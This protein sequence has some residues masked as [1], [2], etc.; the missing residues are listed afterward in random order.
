MET[1][2]M[3]EIKIAKFLSD[4]TNVEI[5]FDKRKWYTLVHLSFS[6]RIKYLWEINQLLFEWKITT[7]ARHGIKQRFIDVSVSFK[8]SNE[9]ADKYVPMWQWWAEGIQKMYE[10]SL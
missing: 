1:N 9:E 5:F 4:A 6:T 7:Y 2:L 10:C 3:E 8:L